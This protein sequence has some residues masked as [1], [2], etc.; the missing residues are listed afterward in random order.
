MSENISG[1]K[2]K[3]CILGAGP[4]GLS[5]ALKLIKANYKVILIEKSS[6]VGGMCRS[7]NLWDVKVDLG[8]HRFIT[9]DEEVDTFWHQ[10]AGECVRITRKTSILFESLFFDYP[11]NLINLFKN[12][13]LIK[14]FGSLISYLST[15]FVTS[16]RGTNDLESWLIKSYGK[17]LYLLFIKSYSE[18]LWG[19]P[20]KKISSDFAKQRI[21]GISLVD[22]I[23]K[24][25]LP[26][27]Q[28]K[29][30]TQFFDYPLE[31]T[32]SVYENMAKEFKS[33]GGEILFNDYVTE[34]SLATVSQ[35]KYKVSR[36]YTA[37]K[38][39]ITCDYLCSTIPLSE[40]FSL[41]YPLK[42]KLTDNLR[43]R[44]TI[45]VYLKV[46]KTDL[47]KDNWI[48]IN[49]PNL[50]FGRVTNYRN[51]SADLF[52]QVDYSVLSL[53]VW[54]QFND[55]TWN[56]SH[57]LLI[58]R[59]IEDIAKTGLIKK[60]WIS[61]SKVIPVKNSYPIYSLDYKDKLNHLKVELKK[62]ENILAIGR[63]GSFRYNN[64]DQ[65]IYNGLKAFE[66]LENNL[67]TSK[68]WAQDSSDQY[69]G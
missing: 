46:D 66:Y 30:F 69:T 20:C 24:I 52:T 17:Y 10:Y 61:D 45:L 1:Y 25:I 58:T 18:R 12:F 68:F 15:F 47:F 22:I 67:N 37:N 49:D 39:E 14:I 57:E 32:G 2:K 26:K 34:I 64:Q 11:I 4:A 8:P 62:V 41:I 31:G 65:S 23:K 43:F 19:L 9:Y 33:Y 40:F 28:K 53:E 5:F 51:W 50:V 16:R 6:Q 60:Q 3:V 44:S 48:Y 42:K 55:A 56:Q 59:C 7:L 54:T 27:Y 38:R 21:Q 36:I 35:G 63:G 29:T 13:P